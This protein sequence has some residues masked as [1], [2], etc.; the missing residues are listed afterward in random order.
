MIGLDA[1]VLVELVW[2]LTAAYRYEKFVV[3]SMVR[4]ILATMKLLVEDTE[5]AWAALR[6][7]KR[8]HSAARRADAAI[9]TATSE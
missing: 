9:A 5:A 1:N 6:A 7:F 2:V 4:Q 3:A 8:V